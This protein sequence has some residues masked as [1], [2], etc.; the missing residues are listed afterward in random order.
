MIFPVNHKAT[1]LGEVE[2]KIFRLHF[3]HKTFLLIWI[4]TKP[5]TFQV[6]EESRRSRSD[7]REKSLRYK[8]YKIG[9]YSQGSTSQT[10][11]EFKKHKYSYPFLQDPQNDLKHKPLYW[12]PDPPENICVPVWIVLRLHNSLSAALAGLAARPLG[13]TGDTCQQLL[14]CCTFC[15]L[16]QHCT[17]SSGP[18]NASGSFQKSPMPLPCFLSSGHA[19]EDL[20]PCASGVMLFI[21]I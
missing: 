5:W 7:Q 12:R 15:Q 1:L 16:Y 11:Y 13:P 18:G 2:S 6:A 8:A 4:W 21:F 3:L 19:A 20:R 17:L 14:G 9:F 10:A